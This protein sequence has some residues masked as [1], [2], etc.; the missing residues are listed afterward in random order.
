MN[1]SSQHWHQGDEVRRAVDELSRMNSFESALVDFAEYAANQHETEFRI[2]DLLAL[3]NFYH[4][5]FGV[6]F[7]KRHAYR[8]Q[9]HQILVGEPSGIDEARIAAREQYAA[10]HGGGLPLFERLARW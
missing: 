6:H 3:T 2:R 10:I 8:E 1:Y 5:E 7:E 4:C 9:L